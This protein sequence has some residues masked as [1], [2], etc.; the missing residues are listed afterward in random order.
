MPPR[1][2]IVYYTKLEDIHSSYVSFA[3]RAFCRCATH[4]MDALSFNGTIEGP[5]LC[6]IGK[7]EEAVELGLAK[8]K[9]GMP[10]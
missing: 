10:K 6:P 9:E 5:T 3:T 8:L 2:E 7:I 4:D 1:C